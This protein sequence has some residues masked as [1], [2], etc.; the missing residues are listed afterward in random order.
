MYK[1][2]DL[3]GSAHLRLASIACSQKSSAQFG[4]RIEEMQFV[5]NGPEIPDSLLQAH[6]EGKV[7]FFCGAG[8]SYPAGLPGFSGLVDGLYKEL[9][10]Y[11]NPIEMEALNRRQYD[12]AI[13]LLERRFPGTRIAIRKKLLDILKPNLRKKGATDTH[14][15]L[16]CLGSNRNGVFRLVTTNFDRIFEII[17]SKRKSDIKKYSA[18][19]LPI[20][21]KKSLGWFGLFAWTSSRKRR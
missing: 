7:V 15:S 14:L 13:D 8:I 3:S 12:A 21:K 10:T 11:P 5:K 18:P 17:T 16:L 4:N 6:E 9:G 20:P 19:F 2:D 1:Q